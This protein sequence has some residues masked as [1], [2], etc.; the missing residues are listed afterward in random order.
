M[1][2]GDREA[3]LSQLDGMRSMLTHSKAREQEARSTPLSSMHVE[4]SAATM[5][6]VRAEQEHRAV[7]APPGAPAPA[8]ASHPAAAA[9]AAPP[10]SAAHE[11]EELQPSQHV[12]AAGAPLSASE[13][14]SASAA[15]MALPAA[16]LAVPRQRPTA[17]EEGERGGDA[18]LA[19]A[20]AD[21]LAGE[22]ADEL[23]GKFADELAGEFAD[24]D[25]TEGNSSLA[26]SPADC[27][28]E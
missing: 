1:E 11:A 24:V 25:L 5:Q 23:T 18:A 12:Q 28:C 9:Q 15:A 22:F 4:M 21:E 16:D 26:A 20:A 10:K 17:S 2:P 13:P 19:P 14:R 27:L 7:P 8:D 6:Q 3:N